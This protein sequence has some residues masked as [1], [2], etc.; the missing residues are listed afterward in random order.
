MRGSNLS[1]YLAV[2]F[3]LIEAIK[4]NKNDL[5]ESENH[6]TESASEQ[7]NPLGKGNDCAPSEDLAS[8]ERLGSF[9]TETQQGLIPWR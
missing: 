3:L 1:K 7:I 5:T 8:K 2:R 4:I 9:N 6:L